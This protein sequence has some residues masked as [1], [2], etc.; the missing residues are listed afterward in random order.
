MYQF[1]RNVVCTKAA[2]I[3]EKKYGICAEVGLEYI[4]AFDRHQPIAFCLIESDQSFPV[5]AKTIHVA[6]IKGG[7]G[8]KTGKALIALLQYVI[9]LYKGQR[10]SSWHSLD[11][12]IPML[13]LIDLGASQIG[14]TKQDKPAVLL[15][16]PKVLRPT[17]RST[18]SDE[19]IFKK[20]LICRWLGLQTSEFGVTAEGDLLTLLSQS[21]NIDIMFY[22]SNKITGNL[23]YIV[24]KQNQRV[25]LLRPPPGRFQ[26]VMLSQKILKLSVLSVTSVFLEEKLVANLNVLGFFQTYNDNCNNIFEFIR[27]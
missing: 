21:P 16:Y 27:S 3:L 26:Y 7:Q 23:G 8:L 11:E 4:E 9:E 13:M 12:L 1:R 18:L 19:A 17:E 10:I 2:K 20:N 15:K 5:D 22:N 24:D 25:L 6:K 14:Y